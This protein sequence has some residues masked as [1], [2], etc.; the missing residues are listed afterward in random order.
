MSE[1]NKERFMN[2]PDS[3][4]AKEMIRLLIESRDALPAISMTSAKLHGIDLT[5]ADRIEACLQPWETTPDD[6]NGI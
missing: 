1:F 6:P 2:S 3:D 4:K 5:L